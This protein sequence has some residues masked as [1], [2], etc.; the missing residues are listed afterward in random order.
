MNQTQRNL[1]VGMVKKKAEEIKAKLVKKF[2]LVKISR[3]HGVSS[4]SYYDLTHRNSDTGELP[5][6]V[7]KELER[8]KEW[9]YR[10]ETERTKRYSAV[11][12]FDEE[13]QKLGDEQAEEVRN[14]TKQL[15]DSV[16]EIEL[17]IQFAKDAEAAQDMLDSLPD[18]D[19]LV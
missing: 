6:D 2:P 12:A 18:V 10:L 7:S 9:D 19:D 14:A 5:R 16:G 8:L 17:K 4:L 3:V 13:L 11:E 15:S 1:L